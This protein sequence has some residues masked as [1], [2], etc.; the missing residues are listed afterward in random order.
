MLPEKTL[1]VYFSEK[2]VKELINLTEGVV[3]G[4][5]VQSQ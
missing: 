4:E 2:S 1:Y 5:L 3:N